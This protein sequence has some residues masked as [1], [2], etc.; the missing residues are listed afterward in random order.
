MSTFA[1]M[2]F[3]EE[4][5]AYE[6]LHALQELHTEGSVTVWGTGVLGRA[7]DGRVSV[8]KRTGDGPLGTGLG[9][10]AG[11]FVGLFGGPP[12]AAV[13][14]ALAVP[15]GAGL[16]NV[17]FQVS[18]RDPLTLGSVAALLVGVAAIASFVPAW[19]ASR[20]DPV[21]ALRGE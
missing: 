3:P 5:K 11:G 14:V 12:G 8:L 1:V 9:A 16:Q 13:G 20:V 7:A 15:L 10:L 4:K 2:V 17:L 21:E 6:G 18:G 19:R